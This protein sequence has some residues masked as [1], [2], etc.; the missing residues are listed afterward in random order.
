MYL[1]PPH[2]RMETDSVSKTLGF[3]LFK[4]MDNENVQKSR[5]PE[6]LNS[7]IQTVYL[8]HAQ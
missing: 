7:N 6:S 5:N 4:N 3:L 2:L 1:N 8:Q